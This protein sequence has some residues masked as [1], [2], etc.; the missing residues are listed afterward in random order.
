MNMHSSLSMDSIA[1]QSG[2]C[3]LELMVISL[4]ILDNSSVPAEIGAH[5]D[6]AVHCLANHL[7]INPL[8]VQNV[9]S[10]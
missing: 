6:H 1:N 9:V 5:L 7:K 3:A 8:L 2:I 10:P 4:E